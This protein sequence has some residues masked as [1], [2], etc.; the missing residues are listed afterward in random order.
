MIYGCLIRPNWAHRRLSDAH[1]AHRTC[2]C[3]HTGSGGYTP[4]PLGWLLLLLWL[5]L[6]LPVLHAM[7]IL[8]TGREEPSLALPF[9]GLHLASTNDHAKGI[10]SV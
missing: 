8:V 2:S 6:L 1:I 7:F 3:R 5:F 4:S 10:T 9:A